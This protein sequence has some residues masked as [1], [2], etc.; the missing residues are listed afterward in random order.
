M[1]II[2]GYLIYRSFRIFNFKAL[3]KLNIIEFFFHDKNIKKEN[4]FVEAFILGGLI[5]FCVLF[6]TIITIA[7][8]SINNRLYTGHILLYYWLSEDILK[9]LKGENKTGFLIIS[10]FFIVSLL[11]VVTNIGSYNGV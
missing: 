8:I 1:N 10:T 9:Y 2:G 7:Y 6:F 5:N 11:Y 4:L 3:I